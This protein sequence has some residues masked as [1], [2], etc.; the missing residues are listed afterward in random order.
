[1][2]RL[3]HSL[4][5]SP[6]SLIFRSAVGL[7]YACLLA[8]LPQAAC[9]SGTG[10]FKAFIAAT[11]SARASFTQSV[12]SKSGRKPLVSQGT[13]AFSRPGKFRW[14]YDK[15]YYQL[16]VGDGERLWIH[17]R[18]LNQVSLRKLGKALG[19]SPAALLA[20]DNE[21]EKNFVIKDAGSGEGLEMVEATPKSQDST[22]SSVRIGFSDDLP[23]VMV[24]HDNFG[25][26]TTLIFSQFERNPELPAKLFHFTPPQ[27]SDIV[28]E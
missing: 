20:G 1:M 17:D 4:A 8:C 14:I 5:G 15:P 2:N 3:P 13:L 9:A 12:V 28:G 11:H 24:V 27:G 18:D 16:I 6:A 23:R 26:T 22:F 25:Q 19:S 10:Q 7:A 21:L